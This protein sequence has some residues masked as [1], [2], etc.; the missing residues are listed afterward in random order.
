M[1]DEK[2]H[3]CYEVLLFFVFVFF[4][5]FYLYDYTQLASG[6]NGIDDHESYNLLLWLL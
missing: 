6:D 5:Y 4:F 1:V 2:I 3:I